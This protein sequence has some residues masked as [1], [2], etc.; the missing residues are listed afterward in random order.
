MT[1]DVR[2]AMQYTQLGPGRPVWDGEGEIPG[3]QLAPRWHCQGAHCAVFIEVQ[4]PPTT[5]RWLQ[6]ARSWATWPSSWCR[7]SW[8]RRTLRSRPPLSPSPAPSSSSCRWDLKPEHM[9][10]E[11]ILFCPQGQIG[12]PYQGFPEPLRSDILKD[13]PRCSAWKSHLSNLCPQDR[14]EA[15]WDHGAPWLRG[16]EEGLG[17]PVP[18]HQRPWCHV[19]RN[20]PSCCQ[21][22]PQVPR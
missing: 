20:V 14:G 7:T 16:L 11:T 5:T 10:G 21:G 3:G 1:N 13:L 2:D 18:Q 15:R 19:R 17:R 8:P 6:A 12:Q 9:R 4:S 22:V